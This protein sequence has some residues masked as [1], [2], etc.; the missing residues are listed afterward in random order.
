MGQD[1]D[2][3]GA[4]GVVTG[5]Q[6]LELGNAVGV[7]GLDASQPGGINVGRVGRVSVAAGVDARVDA[8]RVAVPDLQVQIRDGLAGVD[9]NDLVVEDDVDT[10]LLLDDVVVD[11]FSSNVCKW[12]SKKRKSL[13]RSNPR[14]VVT[15]DAYSTGPGSPP[16]SGCTS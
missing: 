13:Q 6:R 15:R 1:V 2:V 12:V 14:Y 9:V 7:S 4:A 3:R 5:E 10:L 16:G 8:G 11:E